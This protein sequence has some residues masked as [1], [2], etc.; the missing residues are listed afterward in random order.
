MTF[1]TW[2]LEFINV[3]LPIGDLAR[4]IN[5]DVN[6]PNV[7]DKDVIANYLQNIGAC[8]EALETFEHSWEF[9]SRSL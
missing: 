5:S 7:S 8:R 1:K 2:I 9:Y 4:D 6:F 3:N